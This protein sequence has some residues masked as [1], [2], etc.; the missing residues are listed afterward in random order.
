MPLLDELMPLL[1]Q[2]KMAALKITGRLTECLTGTIL[3]ADVI[4]LADS[5][6]RLDFKTALEL[7]SDLLNRLVDL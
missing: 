5:A 6:D 1:R 4:S 2:R 7:A 3:E